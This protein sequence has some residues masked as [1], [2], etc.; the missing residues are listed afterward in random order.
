MGLDESASGRERAHQRRIHA[1]AAAQAHFRTTSGTL[2]QLITPD[3]FRSR[4]TTIAVLGSVRLIL[5]LYFTV[6]LKEVRQQP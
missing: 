6:R 5:S 1:C 2:I 4:V 3:G